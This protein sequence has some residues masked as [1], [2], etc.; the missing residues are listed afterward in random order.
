MRFE[1]KNKTAFGGINRID[2]THAALILRNPSSC[3]TSKF[4]EVGNR[5]EAE[6]IRKISF[7]LRD[8]IRHPT[9]HD[10]R[11]HTAASFTS[12]VLVV[13]HAQLLH[14]VRDWRTLL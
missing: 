1:L 3:V 12:G 9:T 10:L 14:A 13:G 7:V 2:R 4:R 5:R 11:C 6:L 8:D